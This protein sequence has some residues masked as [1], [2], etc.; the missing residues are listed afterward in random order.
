[1]TRRMPPQV[2]AC[3]ALRAGQ[4]SLA[5]ERLV[6]LSP[7]RIPWKSG[8]R[9][10]FLILGLA[11]VGPLF[12]QLERLAAQQGPKKSLVGELGRYRG[13]VGAVH[14]IAL[15]PDERHLVS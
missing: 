7:K 1:M 5:A 6:M 9:A 4:L 3:P 8:A 11:A 13:H 2:T 10:Y 14:N 12:L 15:S